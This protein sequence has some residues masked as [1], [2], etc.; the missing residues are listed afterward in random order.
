MSRARGGARVGGSKP[1]MMREEQGT[2]PARLDGFETRRRRRRREEG[3]LEATRAECR[4]VVNLK[5][6]AAFESALSQEMV[7]RTPPP[8]P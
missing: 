1:G 4:R 3:V 5:E 2:S 6:K 7:L 8:S